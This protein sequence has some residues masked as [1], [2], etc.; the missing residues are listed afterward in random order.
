MA[1]VKP[2]TL[3]RLELLT[4]HTCAKFPTAVKSSLSNSKHA[5]NIS[6]LYSDSAIALSWIKTDPARWHTFF[7]NQVSRNLSM[8]PSTEFFHVPS[9]DNPADLC[10]R[11][12][13]ATQLMAQQKFWFEGSMWL[14]SSFPI[15]P[16]TLLTQEEAHHEVKSLTVLNSPCNLLVVRDNFNSLVRMLRTLCV[17]KGAFKK[18]LKA[19]F[20]RGEM[21]LALHAVVTADQMVHFEAGYRALSN[22][23]SINPKSPI[24]P[25]YSFMDN[26]V[27][28]VGGRLAHGYPMTADQ[29]FPLLVSHRSKLAT[30]AINDVHKRTFMV[31]SKQQWQK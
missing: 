6:V 17:R 19:I 26:G 2:S 25:L 29:R 31:V 13:L 20:G 22:S 30:L 11:G 16:H 9:E 12:F 8:L 4:I 23:E 10:T 21:A 15:Q 28:K 24:A 3:L 7:S 14:G 18:V 27:I 1:P 5:Q